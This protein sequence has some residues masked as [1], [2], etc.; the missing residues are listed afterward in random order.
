MAN[1]KRRTSS[2]NSFKLNKTRIHS[3]EPQNDNLIPSDTAN[4]NANLV[5]ESLPVTPVNTEDQSEDT[6]NNPVVQPEAVPVSAEVQPEATPVN[7][8]SHQEETPVGTEE[9]SNKSEEDPLVNKLLGPTVAKKPKKGNHTFYISDSNNTKLEQL[10]KE[11]QTSP[12]AILDTLL[13]KIL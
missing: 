12:S 7:T 9:N 2:A 3:T 1:E 11:R 6:T 8:E 13:S 10:A 5:T 4:D